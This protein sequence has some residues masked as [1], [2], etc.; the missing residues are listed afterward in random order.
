MARVKLP[1]AAVRLASG[2][3]ARVKIVEIDISQEALEAALGR[4]PMS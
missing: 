3:T 2:D 4:S 1:E